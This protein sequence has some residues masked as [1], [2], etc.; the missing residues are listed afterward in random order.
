[1]VETLVY[2]PLTPENIRELS[3][4][5]ADAEV[6]AHIEPETPTPDWIERRFLVTL[7][8]PKDDDEPQVWHNFAVRLKDSGCVAGSIQATVYPGIVEIGFLFGRKYWGKG[9][10]FQAISWLQEVHL[11]EFDPMNFWATS[12]P[13]N[14]R[15]H[16]LLARL[17]YREVDSAVVPRLLSYDQGDRVFRRLPIGE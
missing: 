12:A 17:G 15:C 7:S 4:L 2:E 10:A 9:I 5:L 11:K 13:G 6:Y 16:V 14:V 8:G 3:R 1:M